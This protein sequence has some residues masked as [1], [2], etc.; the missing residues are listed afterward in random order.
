MLGV[1]I[2][3]TDVKLSIKDGSETAG[4]SVTLLRYIFQFY[5]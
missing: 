3:A 5:F 4:S 1:V 2:G